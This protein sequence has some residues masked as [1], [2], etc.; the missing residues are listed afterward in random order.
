MRAADT[1]QK[2]NTVNLGGGATYTLNEFIACIEDALGKKA[3]IN[4]MG[5]QQGSGGDK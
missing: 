2:L 1:P 3:V 4:Q 5:D